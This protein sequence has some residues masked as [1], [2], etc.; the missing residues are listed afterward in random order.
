MDPVVFYFSDTT[1]CITHT[2]GGDIVSFGS[3]K[4]SLNSLNRIK[5]VPIDKQ[6]VHKK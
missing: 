6:S 4:G 2:L 1:L 5:S 3:L